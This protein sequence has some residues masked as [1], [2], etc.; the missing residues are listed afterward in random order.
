[1]FAR[2]ESYEIKSTRPILK[3]E[4]LA[5]HSKAN[6]DE[7]IFFDNRSSFKPIN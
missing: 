2:L 7:K 5:N 3:T 6:L 4:L 1:M